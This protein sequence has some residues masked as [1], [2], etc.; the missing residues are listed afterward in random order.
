MSL[1]FA[2]HCFEKNYVTVPEHFHNVRGQFPNQVQV[3]APQIMFLILQYLSGDLHTF[4][5]Q[6]SVKKFIE[7]K[8]AQALKKNLVKHSQSMPSGHAT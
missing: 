6:F 3:L 5:L 2:L 1:D 4:F 8:N 7:I